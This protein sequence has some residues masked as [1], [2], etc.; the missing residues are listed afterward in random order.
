MGTKILAG[1]IAFI[2]SLA[3]SGY[4]YLSVCAE[5]PLTPSEY[6]RFSGTV[7]LAT[8]LH[9]NDNGG[10]RALELAK[11]TLSSPISSGTI[12]LGKHQYA[13][14]LPEYSIYQYNFGLSQLPDPHQAQG[15]RYLTFS[16]FEELTD[17]FYSEL[18]KAGWKH[19]DQMGAGHF[20]ECH[21][22][23]MT[24]T[25]HFYLTTGIS[26]VNISI[27]EDN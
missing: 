14:P 23:H 26:E 5:R 12:T 20:F 22:A 16:S 4:L 9:E 25:Q 17:Y 19:T 18:P 21:G 13:F 1:A 6:L 2:S 24:I 3:L 27:V 8:V 7:S 10:A 11:G 15:Q